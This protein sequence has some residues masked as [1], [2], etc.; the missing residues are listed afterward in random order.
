[1][2]KWEC[3]IHVGTSFGVVMCCDSYKSIF[4]TPTIVIMIVF[5]VLFHHT[6]DVLA[7]EKHFFFNFETYAAL[8]RAFLLIHCQT[9]T[10]TPL[11]K[12]TNTITVGPPRSER[13]CERVD[14]VYRSVRQN[15][16]K[17]TL[18][19]HA[20]THHTLN[21][22]DR[23][24]RRERLRGWGAAAAAAMTKVALVPDEDIQRDGGVS[25]LRRPALSSSSSS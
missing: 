6:R 20:R 17:Q 24:I 16:Y 4:I 15:I 3:Y 11:E 22:R 8:K 19:A 25:R 7:R 1:M 10:S 21:T 14:H 23:H 9:R 12:I 18:Y 13:E 5:V 2:Y